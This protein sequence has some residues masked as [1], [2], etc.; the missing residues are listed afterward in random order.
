[1]FWLKGVRI[2][3][4][5][6]SR[7][8]V[9]NPA[10]TFYLGLLGVGGVVLICGIQVFINK[11]NISFIIMLFLLPYLFMSI[12]LMLMAK[13]FRVMVNGTK[14][15]VRTWMGRKYHFDIFEVEHVEWKKAVSG[16][17]CTEQMKIRIRSGKKV[18]I[19]SLMDGFESM[20]DF[21]S[22]NVDESKIH[23]YY[24]IYKPAVNSPYAEKNKS[25]G[26]DYEPSGD[27]P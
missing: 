3:M 6:R 16:F 19:E 7:F 4:K 1:M 20:S 5:V 11:G 18:R 13:V 25:V 12:W 24:T 22:A 9:K 8:T 21:I 26:S 17:I 10:Y 23:S 2:K 27:K 14:V 15:S